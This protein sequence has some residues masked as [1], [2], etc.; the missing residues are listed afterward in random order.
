MNAT[1]IG[2]PLATQV[3][4]SKG[5]VFF[6]NEPKHIAAAIKAIH[7]ITKAQGNTA[8]DST[9]FSLVLEFIIRP[10]VGRFLHQEEAP[11]R[12]G[13]HPDTT[14]LDLQ[15]AP[16]GLVGWAAD[17]LSLQDPLFTTEHQRSEAKALALRIACC[18]C[19]YKEKVDLELLSNLPTPGSKQYSAA[20]DSK[21]KVKTSSGSSLFPLLRLACPPSHA[22]APLPPPTVFD[23]A[24]ELVGAS[25]RLCGDLRS[26]LFDADVSANSVR[27]IWQLVMTPP[28]ITKVEPP[29]PSMSDSVGRS[30]LNMAH[31]AGATHGVAVT[32]WDGTCDP[33]PLL[34]QPRPD[35]AALLLHPLLSHCTPDQHQQLLNSLEEGLGKCLRAGPAAVTPIGDSKVLVALEEAKKQ[36][37]TSVLIS[38]LASR[39]PADSACVLR[40]TKALSSSIAGRQVCDSLAETVLQHVVPMVGLGADTS[41][42]ASGR[43]HKQCPAGLVEDLDELGEGGCDAC[44]AANPEECAP[45]EDCSCVLEPLFQFWECLS[46]AAH[47]S[48]SESLANALS[49]TPHQPL[50]PGDAATCSLLLIS[51]RM[52]AAAVPLPTACMHRLLLTPPA[53]MMQAWAGIAGSA[54]TACDSYECCVQKLLEMERKG[55]G[56]QPAPSRF[57]GE[58]ATVL[59]VLQAPSVQHD[60]SHQAWLV[61]VL[62]KVCTT[63]EGMHWCADFSAE[64]A[65]GLSLV[66]SLALQL[67]A[68]QQQV[69]H[70]LLAA[71][72][73][74]KG[75]PRQGQEQVVF[76]Q[77][78]VRCSGQRLLHALVGC[79][80]SA[81]DSNLTVAALVAQLL[82]MADPGTDSAQLASQAVACMAGTA[83]RLDLST[84]DASDWLRYLSDIQTYVQPAA[85]VQTPGHVH[86]SRPRDLQPTLLSAYLACLLGGAL[87]VQLIAERVRPVRAQLGAVV[88]LLSHSTA[89]G[90]AAASA[91]A[92]AVVACRAQVLS[93]LPWCSS[94][95]A[96]NSLASDCEWVGSVLSMVGT[97]ADHAMPGNSFAEGMQQ[98]QASLKQQTPHADDPVGGVLDSAGL[99]GTPFFSSSSSNPASDGAQGQHATTGLITRPADF[100]HAQQLLLQLQSRLASSGQSQSPHVCT[101]AMPSSCKQLAQLGPLVVTPSMEGTL[102]T[103]RLFVANR[104]AAAVLLEG[105]TGIGKTA[106]VEAVAREHGC[107]LVR[108]NM[109]YRCAWMG[110]IAE[111]LVNLFY[112]QC[113]LSFP[114]SNVLV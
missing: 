87:E 110:M 25:V 78:M 3:T 63:S 11:L 7:S 52:S 101:L 108:Y 54:P 70:L 92:A 68:T 1:R 21:R 71:I 42:A 39:H 43:E 59:A 33:H 27:L 28:V 19:A 77:E 34:S 2:R 26:S 49:S 113:L 112:C 93:L 99:T 15:L 31:G 83:C 104:H 88:L 95:I 24:L 109:A 66:A 60:T 32:W 10:W 46:P 106:A 51:K 102:N 64:A 62:L 61:Q 45:G 48:Q 82:P 30:A 4:Q 53:R 57:A 84:A 80:G 44:S 86:G 50:L 76:L 5:G 22:A 114:N 90:S 96:S 56:C 107:K 79:A 23:T 89:P 97:L 40:A 58:V 72:T 105:A 91:M 67:P 6:N 36:H 35:A 98:I 47:R 103:V 13:A 100:Q 69:V 85:G 74:A 8:L 55:G 65:V 29:H 17:N 14:L 75:D 81:G 73:Q 9:R 16:V 111:F 20:L 12:L 18:A 37:V 94:L 38:L 41:G